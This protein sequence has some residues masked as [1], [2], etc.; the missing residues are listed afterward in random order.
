MGL[1]RILDVLVSTAMILLALPLLAVIS[2]LIKLDSPGP[3]LYRGK[4]MGKGGTV[5]DIFKFRSMISDAS[6]VGPEVTYRHDAR[7]T[8]LG[9]LL[10]KTKFDEL[11]Q[12]F[13]V[14]RGEMSLVG[15]RAEDPK[16]RPSF[17]GRYWPVL[18]LPP[19]MTG[20]SWVRMHHYHEEYIDPG[21]D[22]EKHYVEVSLP[23]K[24][25]VDLE[26]VQSRSFWMDI[27]LMLRTLV[28]LIK[29]QPAP[30]EVE[31]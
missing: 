25:E 17:E 24:L 10:R 6:K 3:V 4:R 14:L 8:R 1:K 21:D 9:G 23:R 27:V 13:N 12:L 29:R 31:P 30:V 5:F 15:P 7:I 18:S 20:L 11:P 2:V 16:Y 26:Y 22:Q 28:E 19:G